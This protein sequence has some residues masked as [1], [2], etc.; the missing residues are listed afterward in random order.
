MGKY[1]MIYCRVRKEYVYGCD[2]YVCNYGSYKEQQGMTYC[3]VAGHEVYGCDHADCNQ[4][5]SG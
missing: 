2:H 1:G 5:K 4:Q 3:K